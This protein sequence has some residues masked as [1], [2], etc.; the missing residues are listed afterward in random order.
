M[1]LMT[2]LI[3]WGKFDDGGP[4]IRSLLKEGRIGYKLGVRVIF[5]TMFSDFNDGADLGK[6]FLD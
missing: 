3:S 1:S 4:D 5:S 6:C 2:S